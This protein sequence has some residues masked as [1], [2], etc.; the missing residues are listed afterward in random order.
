VKPRQ[1]LTPKA[2]LRRSPVSGYGVFATEAIPEGEL[3][4]L[5]A[6]SALSYAEVR[7]LPSELEHLWVQVWFD[8]FLTPT[9]VAEIEP[10]DRM[11]HSCEPN[12]G[13]VGSVA[14]I[15]RRAIDIGEELTFDYGTTETVGLHM[16]CRCGAPGCRGIVTSDDWRDGAFRERNREYLSVYIWQLVRKLPAEQVVR[17]PT[18]ARAAADPRPD[19]GRQVAQSPAGAS[20]DDSVG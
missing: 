18:G 8:L 14:V 11:N 2:E 1:Y 17:P 10:A 20:A 12:C 6:G 3:V 15:A 5:W 19:V 13:V 4:A 7:A 9:R 16:L